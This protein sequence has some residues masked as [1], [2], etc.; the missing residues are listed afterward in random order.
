MRCTAGVRF[1]AGARDFSLLHTVQNGSVAQPPPYSMKTAAVSTGIKRPGREVDHS[2]PSSAE[3]KT[4]GA[5]P[6]LSGTS[7]WS[8][9]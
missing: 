5:I 7:S 6:Q 3:V 1:Q 8:S 2:Y 4:D 9:A